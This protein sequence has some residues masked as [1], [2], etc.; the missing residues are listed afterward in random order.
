MADNAT[1]TFE[2]RREKYWSVIKAVA[3]EL[4]PFS[5]PTREGLQGAFESIRTNAGQIA[6]ELKRVAP[7]A[8]GVL[9]TCDPFKM[10]GLSVWLLGWSFFIWLEFGAVYFIVSAMAMIFMNLGDREE[11]EW[12]AYSVFNAGCR[13]LL[14]TMN[15]E[16]FEREIMR[17]NVAAP[18]DREDQDDDENRR[19]HHPNNR[20]DDFVWVEPEPEVDGGDG[21]G[22][23]DE[24]DHATAAAIAA[25]V[26]DAADAAELRDAG[27]DGSDHESDYE[28]EAGGAGAGG[29]AA[30]RGAGAGGRRKVSGKRARRG[31]EERRE[32]QEERR[33]ALQALGEDDWQ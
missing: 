30:A 6:A 26:A 15:A 29:D 20:D 14:G 18:P 7:E 17:Q 9:K 19:Q 12:S 31:F 33:L 4:K 21:V 24:V 11:G 1:G 3:F 28:D 10:L 22:G 16:Q 5:L 27:G 2:E 32:R 8:V 25:A 13:A 23:D